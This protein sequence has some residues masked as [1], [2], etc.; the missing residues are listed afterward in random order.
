MVYLDNKKYSWIE[1]FLISKFRPFLNIHLDSSVPK[2]S[3]DFI[4]PGWLV[5]P[6]G[7]PSRPLA[8]LLLSGSLDVLLPVRRVDHPVPDAGSAAAH[9]VV[10]DAPR[11]QR[12]VLAP[13]TRTRMAS[14][15]DGIADLVLLTQ[16]PGRVER[17]RR[18]A[19]HVELQLG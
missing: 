13:A 10:A 12:T 15:A 5:P 16:S 11:M 8:S 17:A 4:A 1:Y 9:S 14:T 18:C 19:K 7:L 3:E 2:K 6:Q